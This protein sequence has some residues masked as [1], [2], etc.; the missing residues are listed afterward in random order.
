MSLASVRRSSH[1]SC[2]E[3]KKA[4]FSGDL[5]SFLVCARKFIW[6]HAFLFSYV[7]MWHTPTRIW[8]TSELRPSLRTQVHEACAHSWSKIVSRMTLSFHSFSSPCPPS[9]PSLVLFPS[10]I[11]K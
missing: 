6:L 5:A 4:R 3:S 10:L 9:Y 11:L 2:D 1:W 8:S 7:C